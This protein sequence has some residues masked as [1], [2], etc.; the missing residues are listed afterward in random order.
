MKL[1]ADH[2]LE[3][4]GL[5]MGDRVM[6]RKLCDDAVKSKEVRITVQSVIRLGF[7]F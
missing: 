4:L 1:L 2:E 7:V 3:D 6:L 5:C